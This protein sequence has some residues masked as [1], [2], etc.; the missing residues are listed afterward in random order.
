MKKINRVLLF[1]L[2]LPLCIGF[3]SCKKKND[4]GDSNQNQIEQPTDPKPDD[5]DPGYDPMT[6]IR[7]VYPN[8]IKLEIR[9]S[10]TCSN[11][12]ELDKI[13]RLKEKSV[14]ELFEDFYCYQNN[15]KMN[16]KERKIITDIIK[17]IKDGGE[18]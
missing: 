12:L 3:S 1:L 6:R 5:E 10:K 2:M 17:E 16:S 14:L 9:N 18:E 7:N 11:N 8:A 15:I 4:G 13:E